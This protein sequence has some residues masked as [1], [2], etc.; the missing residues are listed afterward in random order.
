[1]ARFFRKY[2]AITV[3]A[4]TVFVAIITSAALSGS[5][6]NGMSD[7]TSSMESEA[8]AALQVPVVPS[9]VPTELPTLNPLT[10]PAVYSPLPASPGLP[11]LPFPTNPMPTWTSVP[12]GSDDAAFLTPDIPAYTPQPT[13]GSD[14]PYHLTI[15]AERVPPNATV[16][17][18]FATYV[19]DGTVRQVGPA[20]WT[21][22]DGRRP[23]NPWAVDNRHTIFTPVLVQVADYLRGTDVTSE[24][25]VYAIGGAVG[26]DSVAYDSDDLYTFRE[27]ERVILFLNPMRA[28]LPIQTVNG[29]PLREVVDHYT[30]R[31]EKAT[32]TYYNDMN[33]V[34][35][36]SIPLQRLLDDIIRAQIPTPGPTTVTSK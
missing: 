5:K 34:I 27:G 12:I 6:P 19:I 2:A 18:Q 35:G 17:T 36:P 32:N 7:D 25:L 30:I 14:E 20:R 4:A 13:P 11:T 10:P 33:G 24:V 3:L 31:G 26:Q 9:A 29:L 28:V 8:L 15:H 23:A 22:P 16:S 1:M 21:T